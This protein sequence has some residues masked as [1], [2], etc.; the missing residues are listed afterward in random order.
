[1]RGLKAVTVLALCVLVFAIVASAAPN[2]FGVAN[3]RTITFE[4]PIRVGDTL[5]PKG[6][7]KVLHTMDGDN[8][9]MVFEQQRTKKPA[10]A[11]AKCTLVPLTEK[12]ART[13]RAF[14]INNANERVLRELI[15]EGD[16]AKHVF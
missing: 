9:I 8:H 14:T 11:K 4:N 7:Y 3:S 10:E 5:L 6:D 13:Q 12:A 1:M 16:T 15:F 2:Q